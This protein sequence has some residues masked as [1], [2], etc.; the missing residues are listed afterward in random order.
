M[1]NKKP[2]YEQL[3][4]QVKDLA[5]QVAQLRAA[6]YDIIVTGKAG[7]PALYYL[8]KAYYDTKPETK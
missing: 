1:S 4:Q 6:A 5:A 8:E 2:T 3:E 7:G